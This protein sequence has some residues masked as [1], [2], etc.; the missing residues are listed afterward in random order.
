MGVIPIFLPMPSTELS[1]IIHAKVVVDRV[2]RKPYQLGRQAITT[3]LIIVIPRSKAA[4]LDRQPLYAVPTPSAAQIGIL[5]LPPDT[6]SIMQ[7]LV[8]NIFN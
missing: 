8:E 4:V 1:I 7:L 2:N 5:E 3:A 6:S